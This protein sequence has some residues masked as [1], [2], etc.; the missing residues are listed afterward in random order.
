MGESVSDLIMKYFRTHPNQDIQHG[1]NWLDQD[2]GNEREP[3]FFVDP[4]IIVRNRTNDLYKFALKNKPS[5]GPKWLR[6]SPY[7]ARV[8]VSMNHE[9]P[10]WTR[11][12]TNGEID[13]ACRY[14]LSNKGEL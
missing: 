9:Y 7:L 1:I 4:N 10:K 6:L 11:E 3:L 5:L 14:F 13:S 2:Y 8:A 12:Q